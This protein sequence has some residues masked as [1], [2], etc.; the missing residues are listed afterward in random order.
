M[1]VLPDLLPIMLDMI[2]N[3]K[4]GT[5]NFTN[6]GLISHNEILDMYRELCD[7]SFT[8]QNFSAEEQNRILDS[9]RSNNCL[10]ASKL[11]G[12]YPFLPHIR[13]S[14]RQLMINYR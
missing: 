2:R 4:T 7:P 5:Y 3:S 11:K 14:I 8:Y 1:S 10:D 12:E 6:P 9:K 13:D